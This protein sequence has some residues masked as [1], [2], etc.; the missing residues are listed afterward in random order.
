MDITHLHL[1]V[2]DRARSEAFYARWLGLAHAFGAEGITFMTGERDFLLALMDD[3]APAPM[4]AWFHFGTRV[5]SI[6]RLR[7]LLGEMEAAGVPIVKPLHEGPT[8][9][10]FRCA[11]PDGYAIEVYAAPDT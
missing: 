8:V 10:S 5:A 4:P 6:A 9:A 2:R 1:H 7:E 11:D 3:P